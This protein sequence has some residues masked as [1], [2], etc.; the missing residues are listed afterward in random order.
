MVNPRQFQWL[1]RSLFGL[2][3]G[4][5]LVLARGRRLGHVDRIGSRKRVLE[6]FVERAVKTAL[7]LI[8]GPVLF[9]GGIL[10]RVI[11]GVLPA[12]RHAPQW[13]LTPCAASRSAPPP[14]RGPYD[15]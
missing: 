1:T 10:F 2:L 3:A 14:S 13:E 15:F 4:R 9:A 5:F 12:A 11:H 7:G 8:R 6:A